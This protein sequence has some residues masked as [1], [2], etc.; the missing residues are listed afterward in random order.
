M[1]D[2]KAGAERILR[3]T[4]EVRRRIAEACAGSGRNPS[5]VR[6]IAVTKTVPEPIV[7]LAFDAGLED[8]GENYAAELARK[9]RLVPARWH[10]LGKVQ[11]GTAARVADA[12][13]VIHSAEPGGGLEAVAR[14][15][16]SRGRTI[17]CLVQVDFT[18]RRQG[19]APDEVGAFVERASTLPSLRFV[20]LMTLPP[21]GLDPEGARPFF[22]RLRG[23]RDRL[24]E[25]HP[26][27]VELSMGMSGDF[28]V[29]VDE[30]ATM[31]RVGTALFGARPVQRGQLRDRKPA[32][33][34]TSAN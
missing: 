18:G 30:G 9:A 11:G 19:V 2:D 4:E 21:A 12:A 29:A 14:R 23:M 33:G 16:A 32:D 20:G 5:G 25:P 15:A 17:E 3:R 28:P 26:D 22:A 1:S 7:R 8:L 34:G 27:M 6:L 31:V 13:D 10:F 24:R